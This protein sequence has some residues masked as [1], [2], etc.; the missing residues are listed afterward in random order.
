MEHTFPVKIIDTNG[1]S[2]VP[3]EIAKLGRQRICCFTG[4]RP[5]G[6]PGSQG[7]Y[8]NVYKNAHKFGA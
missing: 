5:E 6:L 7:H 3:P 4:H 1:S 2:A 8:R